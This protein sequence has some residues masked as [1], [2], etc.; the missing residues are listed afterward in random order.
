MEDREIGQRLALLRKQHGLSQRELARRSG[1]TNASISQIESG[2]VSPS[3]GVLK[4]LLDGI[5]MKMSEFF[6]LEEEKDTQIFFRAD[7]LLEIGKGGVSYAQ[8]GKDMIRRR[9]QMLSE[10]YQ[11]GA[12][13]GKVA[14]THEGEEAGIVIDGLLEV[15]VDNETAILRSG[16]AYYFDSMRPH[17]FRNIGKQPCRVISACTPPNF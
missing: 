17:R 2:K 13:S 6:A 9:L 11:P 10:V 8:I 15:S 7:D 4:R 5:P 16:D 14:L 12:D 1:A 3:V